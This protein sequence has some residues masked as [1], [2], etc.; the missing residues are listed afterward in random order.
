MK[1]D[2]NLRKRLEAEKAK[3]QPQKQS[4]SSYVA[5]INKPV[6]LSVMW[7]DI[8]RLSGNSSSH[9]TTQLQLPISRHSSRYSGLTR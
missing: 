9:H 3:E 4:W 6:S 2:E 7:R 1:K 8:K 5:G